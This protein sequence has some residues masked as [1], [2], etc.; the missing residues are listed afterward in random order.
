MNVTLSVSFRCN[1]KCKTCYV[2]RN[3]VD[4]LEIQEWAEVFRNLGQ[5]PFWVTISGGEPFL[6]KDLRD[7]VCLLYDI[8]KPGIINIPTNGILTETIV[9]S[10]DAI[11]AYCNNSSLVL[12]VSIDE[13]GENHDTIRGVS[14]NYKK[15]LATFSGLKAL[16][17]PNLSVGIHTVVS[18][19]NVERLPAVYSHLSKLEPDSYVTE[20]AEERVEL[21]TVGTKITPAAEAYYRAADF[22]I[23]RLQNDRFAKLGKITRA[24][25]MRYYRMVK[26]L[27]AQD[28]Q[29]L[30]CFAGVASAHIAPNG[31]VWFCCM[32]AESAGNLRDRQ[33]DFKKIWRSKKARQIRKKIKNEKCHCPLANASYTNMLHHPGTMLSVCRNLIKSS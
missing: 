22:L 7:I 4:E 21:N 25:R 9:A 32:K 1:S 14:G 28:R 27:L 17:R 23:D 26:Q 11:A 8:C 10:V 2:Y 19:Y 30:P 31:D 13:I 24:F 20:I 5:S 12:N 16:N 29:I 3:Q 15:A 6:R 33:Y 18:S